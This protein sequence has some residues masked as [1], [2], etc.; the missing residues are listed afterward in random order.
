MHDWH[1]GEIGENAPTT[2]NAIIEV[3]KGSKAKHELDKPSGLLKLDRISFS[4]VTTLPIT[5]LF[6]VRIVT[7][8]SL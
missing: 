1:E 7:T 8:T 3:P 4:S 5:A 2:V 6:R